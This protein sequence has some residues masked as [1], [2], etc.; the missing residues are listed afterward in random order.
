MKPTKKQICS[1]EKYSNCKVRFAEE[2]DQGLKGT[3]F[4]LLLHQSIHFV[5]NM[6]IK[7]V[8]RLPSRR[9]HTQ[10]Y[11]WSFSLEVGNRRER[12]SKPSNCN[13]VFDKCASNWRISS[14]ESILKEWQVFSS[15]KTFLIYKYIHVRCFAKDLH[16]KCFF[17][18]LE[19]YWLD[20][21][22]IFDELEF[23]TTKFI[24]LREGC[25]ASKFR[26]WRRG[27]GLPSTVSEEIVGGHPSL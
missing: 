3:V 11:S 17:Y 22:D 2:N 7:L 27:D 23:V 1:P 16:M 13:G 20:F 26:M 4:F 12:H 25:W 10:K 14:F 6:D 19:H 24:I 15:F 8:K 5:S 18:W 21:I 9:N